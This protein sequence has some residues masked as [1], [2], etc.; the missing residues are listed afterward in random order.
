VPLPLGYFYEKYKRPA[1]RPDERSLRYD[2]N[3]LYQY[4]LEFGV[5]TINEIR[6][7][8]G[9]APVP[10]GNERPEPTLRRRNA[11][12]DAKAVRAERRAERDLQPN[13]IEPR[14]Q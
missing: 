12:E 2:D 8:L 5:L 10:W 6:Q 13:E 9:L 4:H 1:P 7:S 14:E 11:A 3:N